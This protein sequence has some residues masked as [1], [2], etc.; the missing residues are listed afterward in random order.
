MLIRN[1]RKQEMARQSARD[2]IS[3]CVANYTARVRGVA[4][5]WLHTTYQTAERR[6]EVRWLILQLMMYKI[7]K[8]IGE[9]LA[10]FARI[11][12]IQYLCTRHVVM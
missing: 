2:F 5:T 11:A 4:T 12:G 10:E 8:M 1:K 6:V 9:N 3:R 7:S